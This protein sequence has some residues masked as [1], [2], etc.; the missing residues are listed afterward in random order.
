MHKSQ[1][2]KITLLLASLGLL[3]F[4]LRAPAAIGLANSIQGCQGSTLTSSFPVTFFGTATQ[5]N[6]LVVVA[7]VRDAA[8]INTPTGYSVAISQQT[9]TS[10]PSLAIF[11]KVAAGGETGV[12]VTFSGAT[13]PCVGIYEYSGTALNSPLQGTG[14]NTAVGST[15]LSSGTVSPSAANDLFI[16]G[17]SDNATT[18]TFSGNFT[19]PTGG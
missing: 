3:I 1:T 18:G 2:R 5:N 6:L 16:A 17:F 19:S 10:A 8:T 12:T 7:S 14:S 13:R 11:Y 15:S 9:G 4:P